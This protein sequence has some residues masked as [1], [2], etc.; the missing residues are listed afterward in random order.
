MEEIKT[1]YVVPVLSNSML[2][3]G[4]EALNAWH[5]Y[6]SEV[7]TEEECMQEIWRVIW[8]ASNDNG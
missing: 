5:R 3:A 6:S 8:E 4:A 2:L 1:K 7:E